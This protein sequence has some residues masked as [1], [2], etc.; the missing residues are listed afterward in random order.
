MP[1][2]GAPAVRTDVLYACALLSGLDRATKKEN[3]SLAQG[4]P[5]ASTVID[6]DPE[7]STGSTGPGQQ[8]G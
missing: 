2:A 5:I 1:A 4:T 6:P 8:A 7:I 3:G